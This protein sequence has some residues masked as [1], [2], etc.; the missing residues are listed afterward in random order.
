MAHG[1][2]RLETLHANDGEGYR[3]GFWGLARIGPRSAPVALGL[4]ARL[5]GGGEST[6][7]L[8]TIPLAPAV[9]RVADAAAPAGPLVAICMA[10]CN[11][12]LELF[13]AQIDS[14]RAQTHPD[15]ICVD[16]RRLLGPRAL[17]RARRRCSRATRASWSRARRAGSASTATS[18]ARSGWRRPR[19]PTSPPPT[20]TTAGIRTSSR[21][22]WPSSAARASP[23][24]TRAWSPPT[25]RCSPTPTGAAATTTTRA[26]SRCWWPTRSPARRRCSPPRCS[27]TP[28]PSPRPSSPTS[29]TTGSR[30][31]RCRSATS[32]SSTARSTTT[33]STA[34]RRSAT[35]RPTACPG[36]A[37]GSARCAATRTSACGC[38]GC[39][40]TSTPAG[41]SSSPR[42][43]GCAAATG[44]RRQ[45]ARPRPLRA[46]R[47][48]A[49]A[50]RALAWR[51]AQE[52]LGRRRDT[53]GAE[54]MLFHAFAWRRALAA[55]ARERP[56]R[57]LRLD[58]LPPPALDP[59]AGR[60]PA[61]RAG[62]A[63]DRREDRAAAP[64]GRAT[65]PRA[66]STC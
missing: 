65:T 44:C 6:A 64:C 1:M 37:S 3:S 28:S 5:A 45:A 26:C 15:W 38:G 51:G 63:R 56:T 4:R 55:S 27:R 24:A 52:L 9:E 22:C 53:L 12:P 20:R 19:P 23:T 48:L 42:C 62:R 2:P 11:P 30:S 35:P 21:R 58:A 13:K 29:T 31:W 47:P 59:R 36:C 8:A 17:R 50:D 32:R 61:G 46:R 57:R 18:S 14:I 33:S 7:A 40:T 34:R 10:T 66:A 43:C 41:C 54:W 39:T 60:A 16:Q 49:R 25:A